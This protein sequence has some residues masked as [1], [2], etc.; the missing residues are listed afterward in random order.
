MMVYKALLV[1]SNAR[2]K[3]SAREGETIYAEA[4][5]VHSRKKVDKIDITV[6]NE[7]GDVLAILNMLS[8]VIENAAKTTQDL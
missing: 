6:T 8:Y 5:I 3:K 7:G 4:R 2:F 1:L